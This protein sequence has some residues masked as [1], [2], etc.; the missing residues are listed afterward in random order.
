VRTRKV[1]IQ[2]CWRR[3]FD[4]LTASVS[5]SAE[6]DHSKAS[7]FGHSVTGLSFYGACYRGNLHLLAPGWKQW[8]SDLFYDKNYILRSAIE[9]F[10]Q[11]VT[12]GDTP[13]LAPCYDSS[14]FHPFNFI[15]SGDASK[16]VSK[17]EKIVIPHSKL[18]FWISSNWSNRHKPIL[19]SWS[20]M[21]AHLNPI[22]VS[23]RMY[24]CGR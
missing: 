1:W 24:V 19:C 18:T 10:N 11:R 22:I 13:H 16:E 9:S 14:H 2:T 23:G 5:V 8:N 4:T 21:V 3:K 6:I 17:S 15:R 7:C 20:L 12:H